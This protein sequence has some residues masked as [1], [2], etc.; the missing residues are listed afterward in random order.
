MPIPPKEAQN[1][2]KRGLEL[3]QKWERGGTMIGSRVFLF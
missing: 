3:R 2:A 1:N